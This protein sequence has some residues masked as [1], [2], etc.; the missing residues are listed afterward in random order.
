MCIF[1]NKPIYIYSA[2]S[3]EPIMVVI[4]LYQNQHNK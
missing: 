4:L 1:L 2:M 3:D